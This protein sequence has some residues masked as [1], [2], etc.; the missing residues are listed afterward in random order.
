MP[1]IQSF[2]PS[3]NY[4][5]IEDIVNDLVQDGATRSEANISSVAAKLIDMGLILWEAQN[6]KSSGD[7]D[8]GVEN[9]NNNDERESLIEIRKGIHRTEAFAQTL[10]Q[11]VIDPSKLTSKVNYY[12]IKEQIQRNADSDIG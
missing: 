10:L 12:A 1:R 11:F 3:G 9:G 6:K 7:E 8:S 4:K 5:K 2:V